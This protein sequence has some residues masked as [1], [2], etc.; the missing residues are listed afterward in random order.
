[1]KNQIQM[2]NQDKV[3]GGVAKKTLFIKTDQMLIKYKKDTEVLV[4]ESLKVVHRWLNPKV[5]L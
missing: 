4:K 1:M 3:I 2:N 5:L